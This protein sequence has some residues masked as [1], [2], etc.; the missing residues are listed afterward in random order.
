MA[1]KARLSSPLVPKV[2]STVPFLP[3]PLLP[4]PSPPTLLPLLPSTHH[5]L[6]WSLLLDHHWPLTPVVLE[7]WQVKQLVPIRD[8]SLQEELARQH[9]NERLRRQ[10]AAQ[11]NA[12]GPWIQNKME[13]GWCFRESM[14]RP[15]NRSPS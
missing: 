1:I 5:H 3:L 11:A 7:S 10:F 12:I 8:Q 9:A 13:V 4:L 6:S 2:G 14:S 15:P